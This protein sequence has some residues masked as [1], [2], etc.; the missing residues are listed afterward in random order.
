M[1]AL[2]HFFHLGHV[3]AI[4]TYDAASHIGMI[5]LPFT[6]PICRSH[7]AANTSH[8]S[9]GMMDESQRRRLNFDFATKHTV[10]SE[11]S[12]QPNG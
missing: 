6:G 9:D 8:D 10:R 2:A 5:E 4:I 3:T 1:V 11:Q 7:S 12:N